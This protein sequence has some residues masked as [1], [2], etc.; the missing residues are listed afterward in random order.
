MTEQRRLSI[1]EDRRHELA[2]RYAP[3]EHRVAPDGG[4]QRNRHELGR[5]QIGGSRD[6]AQ[7]RCENR[8]RERFA[9]GERP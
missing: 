5:S 7:L 2:A 4:G 9:I 3:H 1:A 8:G 6:L